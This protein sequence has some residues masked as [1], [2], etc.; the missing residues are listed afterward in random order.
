[1][2]IVVI[3]KQ[4]WEVIESQTKAV[5]QLIHLTEQLLNNQVAIQAGIQCYTLDEVAGF[6]RCSIDT[7]QRWAKPGPNGEPPKLVPLRISGKILYRGSDLLALTERVVAPALAQQSKE[8]ILAAS[9]P[10]RHRYRKL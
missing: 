8:D 4:E 2:D 9:L 10:K 7:V 6:F 5:E 3:S 1:M